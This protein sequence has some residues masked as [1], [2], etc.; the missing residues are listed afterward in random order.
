M[1][2]TLSKV[3]AILGALGDLNI[4]AATLLIVPGGPWR[5]NELDRLRRYAANGYQLAGHGWHHRIARFGGLGHRLHGLILSRNVAEHLALDGAG[6]EALIG[7]CH[8]WF[9]RH[10]L[11]PASLYVPPAWAMGR[12]SR[13]ALKR[14]PFRYYEYFSGIYDS[15]MD[16]FERIPMV[17]YEA[18]AWYRA[19]F[20]AAW[21]RAN[22]ASAR[23]KQRL[24]FSIHPND[25]ELL[26]RKRLARDLRR[27]SPELLPGAARTAT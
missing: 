18:D 17:G 20:V 7:R 26:M 9:G 1:P 14:L 11:P 2:S 21:N 24:R 10:D 25:F 19:P 6:I 22:F 27:V 4:A 15:R 12:I 16:C 5:E 8:A 13:D 23:R 3:D